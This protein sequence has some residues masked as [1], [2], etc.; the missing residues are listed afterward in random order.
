MARMLL[1]VPRDRAAERETLAGS[2]AALADCE[3]I[4]D[5]RVAE[6]R[7]RRIVHPYGERRRG[8]RRSGNLDGAGTT[9]LFIH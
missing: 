6:R 9:V 4:V 3:V 5:R 1:I 8:E 7:R 2:F